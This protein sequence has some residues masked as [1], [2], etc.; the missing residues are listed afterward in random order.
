[1]TGLKDLET[2][3]LCFFFLS[4]LVIDEMHRKL[5][6]AVGVLNTHRRDNINHRNKYLGISKKKKNIQAVPEY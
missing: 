5:I 3:L 6:E 2:I 4:S 1:M